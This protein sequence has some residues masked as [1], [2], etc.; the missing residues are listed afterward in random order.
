MADFPIL[1]YLPEFAQTHVHGVNDAIQLSHHLSP[2][3]PL[4][5]KL[6]QDQTFFQRVSSFHQL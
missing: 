2:P 6:F 5:L 3:S 4:A 1:H